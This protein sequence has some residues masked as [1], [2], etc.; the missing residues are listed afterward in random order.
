MTDARRRGTGVPPVGSEHGRDAHATTGT[1]LG[2]G[3]TCEASDC[4]GS[5]RGTGVPPV[6]SEHGRDA[7][8][9]ADLV[10]EPDRLSSWKFL[11]AALAFGLFACAEA[12]ASQPSPAPTRAAVASEVLDA[13]GRRVVDFEELA[14]FAY[15][16]PSDGAAWPADTLAGIPEAVRKLAGRRV[17][18]SGFMLPIKLEAGRVTQF[19]ILRNQMACCYGVAPAPN[20]W[21]VARSRAGLAAVADTPVSYTGV[22]RV[23]AKREEGFFI[24]IY[25]LELE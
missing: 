20:E 7:H 22:L 17:S 9:T 12:W 4:G 13:A 25:E 10:R 15:T 6:G 5:K 3:F 21:I 8:A 1:D 2:G 14:G 19:L 16:P 24:G 18:V 11:L 23:G